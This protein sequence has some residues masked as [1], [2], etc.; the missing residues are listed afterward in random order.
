ML[1][2]SCIVIHSGY[3]CPS[4]IHTYYYSVEKWTIKTRQ[5]I[6]SDLIK[7]FPHMGECIVEELVLTIFTKMLTKH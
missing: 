4:D 3:M 1:I 2:G 5:M 6:K 7:R